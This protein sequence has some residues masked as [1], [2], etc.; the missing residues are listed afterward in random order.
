MNN[1]ALRGSGAFLSSKIYVL[2]S[3]IVPGLH[4]QSPGHTVHISRIEA[5]GSSKTISGSSILLISNT[6]MIHIHLAAVSGL[7][8]CYGFENKVAAFSLAS[9]EALVG[10]L[11]L[12]AL[13]GLFVQFDYQ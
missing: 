8:Q 5:D 1:C 12:L 3:S 6:E 10:F 13:Q 4:M 11:H 9:L 2:F 7:L